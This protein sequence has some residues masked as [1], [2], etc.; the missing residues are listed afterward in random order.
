M[1]QIWDVLPG[2]GSEYTELRKNLRI[3]NSKNYCSAL[4]T[5]IR[6]VLFRIWIF[7]YRIPGEKIS[8]GSRIR[9]NDVQVRYLETTQLLLLLGNVKYEAKMSVVAS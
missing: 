5:M 4:S 8:T 1:L 7:L 3:F 9:N 2:F 6:N